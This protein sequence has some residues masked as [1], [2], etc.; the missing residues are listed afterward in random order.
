[1]TFTNA[2]K[3]KQKEGF[4][5]V[6]P[7]IKCISPKDG[8]LLSGRNPVD[9]AILLK[10]AGAPVL[11]VVTENKNFGGSLKLLEETSEKT[12]LPILCKD[13]FN[14]EIEL[15]NA[16]KAGASAVLLMFSCLAYSELE[17]LYYK[18]YD[19]GLEVLAETHNEYE[20]TLA[21]KLG[22]KIIGINNRDITLLEKDNGTVSLIENLASFIP[23]NTLVISE[24]G[25]KSPSD[26][27]RAVKSGADA[28]LVGTAI[29]KAPDTALF[30][31]SLTEAFL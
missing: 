31:K 2:I 24:S 21:A 16:K 18:A 15:E 8:E 5:P 23:E 9:I 12:S 14:S 19:I 10:E 20:L 3:L 4:I 22:A 7:D 27:K 6:I 13:F 25:I 30:Y 11:S 28:V 29:L 17:R 1:M 26:V